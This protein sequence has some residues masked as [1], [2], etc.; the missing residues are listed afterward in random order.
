V[1]CDGL[2]LLNLDYEDAMPLHLAF[3]GTFAL[4]SQLPPSMK[5]QLACVQDHTL[6]PRVGVWAP[7][8]VHAAAKPPDE[9]VK[10]PPDDEAPPQC[11][12][13]GFQVFPAEAPDIRGRG[14]HPC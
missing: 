11:E 9:W 2:S 7:S 13:H 10:T 6:I 14:S 5:P 12:S 1:I 3:W 8:P 4:E